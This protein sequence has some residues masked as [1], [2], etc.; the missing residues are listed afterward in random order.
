[1]ASRKRTVPA[2]NQAPPHLAPSSVD[3]WRHTCPVLPEHKSVFP[4]DP[5]LW[6]PAAAAWVWAVL[7]AAGGKM[8]A[9]ELIQHLAWLRGLSRRQARGL[10]DRGLAVLEAFRL[11]E[12]ERFPVL[13]G[14]GDANRYGSVRVVRDNIDLADS[15]R[16]KQQ[17]EDD[18]WIRTLCQ[19][20]F[21]QEDDGRHEEWKKREI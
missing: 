4:A 2:P 20:I 5:W 6:Q 14:G 12:V 9:E 1:M 3:R 15:C 17:A 10:R 19:V 11:V 7:K 21:P 18:R 16:R 13:R 8:R